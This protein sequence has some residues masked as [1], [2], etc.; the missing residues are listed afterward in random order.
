M[1]RL[2]SAWIAGGIVLGSVL[3]CERAPV[4][5]PQARNVSKQTPGSKLVLAPGQSAGPILTEEPTPKKPVVAQAALR[6]AAAHNGSNLELVIEVHIAAGWHTFTLPR[7]PREA[8][9]PPR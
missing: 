3:G 7:G 4:P 5:T 6:P 8:A 2:L 9:S 1:Q